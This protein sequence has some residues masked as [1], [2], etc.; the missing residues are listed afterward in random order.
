MM[1]PLR[2]PAPGLNPL[3]CGAVVASARRRRHPGPPGQVSIPFIAGQWS[4]RA[5]EDQL[6]KEM[7]SQSPSLRG[8]GRFS[9]R[10]RRRRRRCARSQ[11]PSLR[12]S[13]RFGVVR[14]PDGFLDVGLNPLHCGAVVAS[15]CR[16]GGGAGRCRVSIPFIAGQWSLL[17]SPTRETELPLASQSP[18]LRGSGR[19]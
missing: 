3:H 16:R 6:L 7:S 11:S 9:L 5:S 8:S 17:K 15:C 10:Q 19:F 13:G 12:G 1:T 18:S 2:R 14:R 4:L